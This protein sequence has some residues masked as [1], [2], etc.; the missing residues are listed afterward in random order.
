MTKNFKTTFLLISILATV[1][2]GCKST[3]DYKNFAQAGENFAKANDALLDTAGNVAIN[4]TSERLLSYRIGQEINASKVTTR[5][6]ELSKLDIERLELINELRNHNQLLQA[7]FDKLIELA[8]SDTPDR[9]QK[10]V[11]SIAG[12]LQNS[13][14]KLI[15]FNKIGKLPSITKIVLDARIRGAIRNEL[16]KRKESIYREITIQEE[17]LKYLSNSMEDD[18]KLTRQLQ[19]YRIVLKPLLQPGDIKEDEW[20]QTRNKVMTQDSGTIS[21]INTASVSL[22]E[23]KEVFIASIEGEVTSKRLK[24]FIQET[25]SFSELVLNKE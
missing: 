7:Y 3:E 21:T 8:S 20:I 5:Y 6:T 18:I 14:I 10:S 16:E 25:N 11:D 4:A 2:T 1:A 24:K 19:E 23:F 12:Q 13:G 22:R 15:N 17:L 9:T